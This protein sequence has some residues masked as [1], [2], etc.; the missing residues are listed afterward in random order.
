VE[1]IKFAPGAEGAPMALL[2]SNMMRENLEQPEKL[3]EFN[4]L[5]ATVQILVKDVGTSVGMVFDGGS[6]TFH[7][8]G[9]GTADLS[10]ETDSETLLELANVSIKFG[11][12][13]YFDEVGLGILKKL[14][15]R[16]LKIGGML[17]H[18]IALTRLSK[19]MSIN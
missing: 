14:L 13:Y 4:S 3:K 2:L 9:A 11:L 7:D 16:E 18:P 6:L 5:K 17:T 10:I 12:P 1:R 8:G 15:K 19:V